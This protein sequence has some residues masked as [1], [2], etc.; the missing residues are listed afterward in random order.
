MNR[1]KKGKSRK[2]SKKKARSN[3][4][5]IWII[6][7]IVLIPILYGVYLY[8][9]QSDNAKAQEKELQE[10]VETQETHNKK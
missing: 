9:R 1:N 8:C 7:L 10:K 3:Y 5:F 4:I 6:V 2:T